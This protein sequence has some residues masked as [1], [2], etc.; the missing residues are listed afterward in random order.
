MVPV[1][2][3]SVPSSQQYIIV[4]RVRT[5]QSPVGVGTTGKLVV[6]EDALVSLDLVC[7]QPDRPVKADASMSNSTLIQSF[8]HFMTV[9]CA[10]WTELACHTS[11]MTSQCTSQVLQVQGSPFLLQQ[12]CIPALSTIK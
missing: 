3:D 12:S 1:T 8:L 10:L 5:V 6:V 7:Q 2:I 4:L 9:T 11:S